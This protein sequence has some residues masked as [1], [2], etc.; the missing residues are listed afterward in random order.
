VLDSGK[1]AQLAELLYKTF[2]G[3]E[4]VYA[5]Q[6]SAGFRPT[7]RPLCAGDLVRHVRGEACYGFYLMRPGDRVLCSALD[8]DGRH[9]A[10]W[11]YRASDVDDA[12]RRERVPHLMEVSQSGNGAHVWVTFADPV[13]ASRVR[14]WWAD[15]LQATGVACREI[16]PRQDTVANLGNLLRYPLFNQSRF[17]DSDWVEVDALEALC[18]SRPIDPTL[19]PQPDP[20]RLT[21]VANGLPESVVTAL[22]EPSVAARW[23][24]DSSGLADRSRS[25]VAYSLVI[26]LIRAMVPAW[27][28]DAALR[29]WGERIGYD[30]TARQSW[31][32]YTIKRAYDWLR[33]GGG[34]AP[35]PADGPRVVRA[36]DV[37]VA[38]VRWLWPDRVALG[39]L[40]LFPGDPGLGKS[41]VTLDMAARV[42]RGESWP[43]CPG[44]RQPVGGVVLMSAED[45]PADTIRP[46]LED[47]DADL[48]RVAIVQG[49]RRGDRNATFNLRSDLPALEQAIA[50]MPNCRLVVIDPVSAYLGDTDSHANADVRA[51]LGPLSELAGRC[52]AAFVCVSHLNKSRDGPAMYRATG[53]MAF[54]AAARS[55]WMFTR[56]PDDPS[57]RRCFMLNIKSNLSRPPPGLAYALVD[58]S[59]GHP[60]VAWEREL[61]HVTAD[62]ATAYRP[63]KRDN[64]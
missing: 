60:V 7:E 32:N 51:V 27:D 47:A 63:P 48:A 33:D 37:P 21:T 12:L 56:D 59:Q 34:K 19:L 35:A 45:D 24:G 53:S 17:V 38:R 26:G 64:G 29:V 22:R 25:A 50:A 52:G 54:V 10:D 41:F 2:R 43:D 42:T 57:R 18:A 58:K 39:K 8:F 4:D 9:E 14:R 5:V 62:E 40:T 28:I 3:R 6:T 49:V 13:E 61:V 36:C 30:K 16:F 11:R 20:P 15:V 55:A 44:V 46:R 23:D 31:R 1:A